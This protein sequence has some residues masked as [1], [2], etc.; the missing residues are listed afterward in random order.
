VS[1]SV[2]RAQ[3]T[4]TS[5]HIDTDMGVDDGLALMVAN[6][7]LPD[8]TAIS[9]VFGNVPL[10]TAFRNALLFRE[11]LG[12]SDRWRVLSGADHA[13][14]R[15]QQNAR[16]VH[17]DDGLGGATKNIDPILLKKI[18][19]IN[20]SR[21]EDANKEI[22]GLVTVI[23]IGPA[24]NIPKIV[25][26]YGQS[27][28]KRVVLMSG[29]FFDVGNITQ[30][31]EFNAFSDPDALR[32]TINIGV[33]VTMVPLDI[34]R[35][36]QLSRVIMKNY[37]CN[38]RAPIAK[39]LMDAHMSY[40]DF[41]QNVEGID[42]CFPHDSVAVLAA[43]RP[44]HFFSLRGRVTIDHAGQTV[45]DRDDNSHVEIFTGGNLKWVRETINNLLSC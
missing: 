33:P 34:C 22:A 3:N 45:F 30:T 11:L 25:A 12:R 38:S 28:I 36:I 4:V 6:A 17:G 43:F 35:K 16:E 24:T 31:A 1:K 5:Y 26:L 37:G 15:E 18:A 8:I 2:Q 13:T 7:L 39:L 21:L 40:M 23:G 20:T 44:E 41:Y 27:N 29:S 14:N 32:D 42:G 10:K 9:C 19:N